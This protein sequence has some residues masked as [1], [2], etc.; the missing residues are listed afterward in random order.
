VDD[1]HDF[2]LEIVRTAGKIK[3]VIGKDERCYRKR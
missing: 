2:K 3:Y 1:C